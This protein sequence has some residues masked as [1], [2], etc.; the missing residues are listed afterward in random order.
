MPQFNTLTP[1]IIARLTTIVG[2]ENIST[3]HADRELHSRDQSAHA[4]H[5]PDVVIWPSSAQQV[6]DVLRLANENCV[7]VTPWGVGTSLEG[8]C[9]AVYGGILLSLQRMNKI[10]EVHADDFQVTVQPGI[11]YKDMNADLTRY[12][13]FFAPD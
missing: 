7:P 13:L 12:G 2:T 1:E 6:A 3:A 9:V 4:P 5:M 8:N 11:P 10:V